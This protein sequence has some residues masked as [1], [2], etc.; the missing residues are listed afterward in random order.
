MGEGSN[1]FRGATFGGFN[2][3]DVIHYLSASETEH[4]K[5]VSNLRAELDASQKDC[6]KDRLRVQELE[7]MLE[8]ETK[9]N[10]EL[11]EKLDI[12]VPEHQKTVD[13]LAKALDEVK[14]LRTIASELEPKA[15]A[16]DRIKDRAAMIEL[17]AHER[18][19]SAL[20]EAKGEVSQI[21]ENCT[22]WIQ[23]VQTGYAR[24]RGE[25]NETFTKS[26]IEL[27]LICKTFDRIA[28]EF[29]GHE[30]RIQT[31]RSKVEEMRSS[32]E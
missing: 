3:Q 1:P 29:D 21:Q 22:A 10:K 8:K 31:I 18:A 2:R 27:E 28:K 16:Y 13:D 9:S 11:Q 25:L 32:R 26:A 4:E 24:L 23:E 20:D 15:L 12:L 30:E 19:Q 17:D 7:A 14:L 5:I 6:A